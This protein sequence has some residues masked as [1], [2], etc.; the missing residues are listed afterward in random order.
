MRLDQSCR[1]RLITSLPR[2]QCSSQA[3]DRGRWR[4]LVALAHHRPRT[5]IVPPQYERRRS[6]SRSLAL[7][8]ASAI[9]W[10]QRVAGCRLERGTSSRTLVAD[11]E[12]EEVGDSWFTR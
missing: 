12:L 5:R 4:I 2:L 6:Q 8:W 3:H 11:S 7:G 9:G 1:T 10:G